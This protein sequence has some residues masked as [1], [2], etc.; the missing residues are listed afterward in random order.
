MCVCVVCECVGPAAKAQATY[1]LRFFA[2]DKISIT[3]LH[4]RLTH[5]HTHVYARVCVRV[6][7]CV[8]Q[9]GKTSREGPAQPRQSHSKVTN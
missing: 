3:F 8:W 4:F 9:A 2:K 1:F 5:T 7:V 6:F